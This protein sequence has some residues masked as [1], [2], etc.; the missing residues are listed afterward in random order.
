VIVATEA[1]KVEDVL[2]PG[3]NMYP[4]PVSRILT[5]ELLNPVETGSTVKI[6]NIAGKAVFNAE[7]T[8]SKVEID[9]SGL[10]RGLYFVAVKAGDYVTTR[11]LQIIK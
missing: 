1:T 10:D 6:F 2:E 3:L 8:R 11:K 7:Y 9:V 5:L 4:N